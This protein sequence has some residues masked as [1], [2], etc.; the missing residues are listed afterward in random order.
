M[1][2]AR[3]LVVLLLVVVVPL[4]VV[5]LFGL[6]RGFP[7]A[8]LMTVF[9]YAVA[10]A[11][12]AT[13]GAVLIGA[14]PEAVVGIL[15]LVVGIGVLVPRVLPGSGPAVEPEGPALTVAVSN[16]RV[17]AGDAPT[18]VA[19]VE[20]YGIDVLVI[21]ELTEDSITRL[22]AAGLAEQL[23]HHHAMPSRVTSGGAIYS[24]FPLDPLSPSR[25]RRFGSTPRAM[26]DVPGYGEVQIDAVHPLPPTGRDWT[27]LWAD[28]LRS[29]PAP[30]PEGEATLILAGD[31]NATHDHRLFRNLLDRGWVD[32][33][34]ARGAAL[35]S[36]FS[37]LGYG[38]PVPP[39]TLDHVLVD[40]RVRVEHIDIHPIP[41]S[42]H[43]LVSVRLRL[44]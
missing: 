21:L 33:A 6:D 5:R 43:R 2:V 23:E 22:A 31:F 38:E 41:G 15:A 1:I 30:S 3:A 39:V 14:W 12:V 10:I 28:A 9:P 25:H 44:P 11:G 19:A 18:V 27:P 20:E 36:T 26:I 32:A 16:L 17:G 8:T 4:T 29:L 35:R 42:D 37:A 34:D 7:L 40:R 24:R 13:V